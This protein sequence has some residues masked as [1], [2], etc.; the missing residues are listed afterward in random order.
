MTLTVVNESK[1]GEEDRV[2]RG[3]GL[4][5][6]VREDSCEEEI[7]RSCESWVM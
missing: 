2:R 3:A 1:I 6:E 4:Y 7:F 5:K